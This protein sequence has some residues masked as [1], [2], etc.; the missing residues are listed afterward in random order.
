MSTIDRR[1]FLTLAG[2]GSVAAAAGVGAPV[3]RLVGLS[4]T[5]TALAFRGVAALPTDKRLPE[6]GSFVVE[7]HVD[8]A[9]GTG[10]I[11]KVVY[12][13]PPDAMSRISL[14][15][16]VVRVEQVREHGSLVSIRGVVY[17]RNHL[18]RGESPTVNIVIDRSRGVMLSEF[19]DSRVTLAM[20]NTHPV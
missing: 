12:A 19:F 1:R 18:M 20:E 16:H 8:I 13:G 5:G 15:S 14:M 4:T 9:A 10:T 2:A 17:D 7:G 6:W 3:A 11:T